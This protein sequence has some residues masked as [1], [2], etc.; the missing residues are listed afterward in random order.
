M[1]VVPRSFVWGALAVS[2]LFLLT[3]SAHA[4]P[5][6]PSRPPASAPEPSRDDLLPQ[7]PGEP[8]QVDPSKDQQKLCLGRAGTVVL[9]DTCTVFHKGA[10]GKRR[11]RY[12][13]FYPFNSF[14]P[15][16]PGDCTL[17]FNP[18]RLRQQVRLTPRQDRVVNNASAIGPG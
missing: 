4:Q 1:V 17:L 13:L 18:A 12:T 14:A 7:D 2:T 15:L 5:A 8:P 10:V 9:T 3:K 6:E 11:D 16:S